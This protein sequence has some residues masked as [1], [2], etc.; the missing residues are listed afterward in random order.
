M[1]VPVCTVVEQN[2]YCPAT[3]GRTPTALP[4]LGDNRASLSPNKRFICDGDVT[5]INY[6]QGGAASGT[7][8]IGIWEQL[9]G[10]QFVLKHKVRLPAGAVGLQRHELATP[11]PFKRGDFLGI[12]YSSDA[13]TALISSARA[14]DIDVPANEL[15]S[16]LFVNLNDDDLV[17][18]QQ[19]SISNRDV[20]FE[21]RA[22]ALEAELQYDVTHATTGRRCLYVCSS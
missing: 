19:I 13:A 22:F 10:E 2:P 6:H 1:C 20:R 11:L 15:N 17:P 16:V 14:D 7:T 21:P 3:F 8:F 9:R 18:G 4:Y 12:H 5:A